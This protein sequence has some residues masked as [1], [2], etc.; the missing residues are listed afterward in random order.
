M[1]YD[2]SDINS[3][4]HTKSRRYKNNMIYS[5]MGYI[6]FGLWSA[7]KAFMTLTMNP[8]V[9]K[10]LISEID[11]EAVSES[12]VKLVTGILFAIVCIILL[13]IHVYIGRSAIRYAKGKKKSTFFLGVVVIAAILTIASIPG[14]FDP[15]NAA[16]PDT[17]DSSFAAFFVDI[18]MLFI[19]FD[20]LY[21]AVM[22]K[23]IKKRLPKDAVTYHAG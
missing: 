10:Y 14:Y 9:Y 21:S 7:V 16:L 11:T 20:I 23:R 12:A 13:L 3:Y 4:V 18:T 22:L 2:V 1:N 15:K 17:G 19:L 6:V 5:G 8:E